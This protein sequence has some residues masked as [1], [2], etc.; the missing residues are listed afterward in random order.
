[1]INFIWI[2]NFFNDT[3]VLHFP[4]VLFLLLIYRTAFLEWRHL[5]QL[6]EWWPAIGSVEQCYSPC[7]FTEKSMT[8]A[9]SLV[10]IELPDLTIQIV[11]PWTKSRN[12]VVAVVYRDIMEVRH[13]GLMSLSYS[14]DSSLKLQPETFKKISRL[15]SMNMKHCSY[16]WMNIQIYK[17]H[18]PECIYFISKPSKPLC[19]YSLIPGLIQFA[20]S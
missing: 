9:S 1:M 5:Q 3:D 15:W 12:T 16:Y 20:M 10:R 8:V 18:M 11:E 6:D 4:A 2:I 14:R 17:M 7:C 19:I 13:I